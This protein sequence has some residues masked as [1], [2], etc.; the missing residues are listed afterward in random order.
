MTTDSKQPGQSWADG[1]PGWPKGVRPIS[2]GG[3][4]LLGVG[5]DGTLYWDGKPIVV[6]KGID[7]TWWQTLIAVVAALGAFASG[8]T[9]LLQY[10]GIKP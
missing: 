7:L 8:L 9:D 6:R 10:L 1:K 4:G 2:Y 5:P 3:L